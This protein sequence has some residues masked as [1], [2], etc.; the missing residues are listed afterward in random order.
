MV[1]R[2]W[3]A[4]R[5]TQAPAT[6]SHLTHPLPRPL[7][8]TG[9]LYRQGHVHRCRGGRR[10]AGET[11]ARGGLGPG[12]PERAPHPPHTFHALRPLQPAA[13]PLEQ[14]L[15]RRVTCEAYSEWLVS[16][17]PASTLE[18]CEREISSF[19]TAYVVARC[20]AL[21]SRHPLC[22]ALG[23]RAPCSPYARRRRPRPCG[24]TSALTC[25]AAFSPHQRRAALYARQGT[26]ALPA[27]LFAPGLGLPQAQDGRGAPGSAARHS[28]G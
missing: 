12:A 13:S 17:C 22:S 7:S 1:S 28:A 27:G 5:A 2:C 4:P 21:T 3:P 23:A 14:L 20:A 8:A 11:P 6:S 9:L 15:Q 19:V 24:S 10:R 26:S 18:E 16:T 25:A